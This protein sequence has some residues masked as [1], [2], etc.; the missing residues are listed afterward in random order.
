[1]TDITICLQAFVY[2]AG[3]QLLASSTW[4][5]A[6]AGCCGLIAGLAYQSNFLGIKRLKV[7]FTS[8]YVV[9]ADF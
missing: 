6:L 8:A 1:M 2:L 9:I 5:S 7:C 4:R 3:I